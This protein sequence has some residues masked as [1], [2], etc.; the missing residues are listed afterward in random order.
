MLAIAFWNIHK[1]ATIPIQVASLAVKMAQDA[2]FSGGGGDVLLCLGEP[3]A[4]AISAIETHL[5]T[6]DPSGTWSVNKSVSSR[7]ICI[8]NINPAS[9]VSLHE[10]AGCWCHDITRMQDG[11]PKSYTV[12]FVHLSAPMNVSDVSAHFMDQGRDL[13]EEILVQESKSLHANTIAIGDFNMPPFASGMVAAKA[14]NAVA[15]L[16]VAKKNKR[17]VDKREYRYFYNPMWKFLGDWG[18]GNQRGSYYWSSTT[19]SNTW[20]MIDQVLVRPDLIP[21]LSKNPAKILTDTGISKLTTNRGG[22]RKKISDHLPVAI[23]LD[24]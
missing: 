6:M 22:I 4:I 5:A 19:D 12:W 8:S 1:N 7:F 17:I 11:I 20:H 18:P 24:I 10:V 9:H 16:N 13:R 15:C 14:L 2:I 3:G 21:Y 23:S